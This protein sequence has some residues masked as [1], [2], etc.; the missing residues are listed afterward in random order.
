MLA[1]TPGPLLSFDGAGQDDNRA[2]LGGN[3]LPPDTE[4]DIGRSHYVQMNNLVFEIFDKSGNSVLGPLPNNALWTD[5]G[6]LCESENDGDPIVLYDQLADRWVFTQFAIGADGHQCF[7]VSQTG[8]PTGA[9][10]LYDFVVSAGAFND[11]PKLAIWPNGYFMS[12]NEFACSGSCIFTSAIATVFEREAMLAGL[13][14]RMVTWETNVGFSLQPSHWE[15]PIAPPASSPNTFVMAWDDET[16][17]NGLGPDGYRLW[18]FSVDWTMDPPAS[19]FLQVGLVATAEFDANLCSFDPCIPQAGTGRRLDSLSQFTMYRASY[20]NFP[21]HQTLLVNHTVDVSGGDRAGIRWAELRDTGGG[22]SLFQTGTFAGADTDHRWM[23]SINID[24]AGNI[25]LGYSVSGDAT[26]PSIRYTSRAATDPLGQMAGGEV[27][28]VAGTGS[29]TS[30]TNR[31]GDYSTLSVD[32]ADD[33][34][35]WLTSE[36]YPTTSASDFRTRICS[37]RLPNDDGS[38]DYMGYRS[39]E[40]SNEDNRPRLLIAYVE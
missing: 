15:G 6:G 35:F 36:Y 24:G 37:F 9:Y 10:F 33:C 20:R 22:W 2:V 7:A 17:G 4:G 31:W 14:A 3:V 18:N 26:F 25:A 13:P 23:G 8:D 12:A 28:C 16:W 5:F 32:P 40:T 30:S 21:D 38:T 1:P 29:Q 11:Y 39:S 19:S 34:T 27:T